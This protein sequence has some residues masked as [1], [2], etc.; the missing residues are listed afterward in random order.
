M[1]D[2]RTLLTVAQ[3]VTFFENVTLITRKKLCSKSKDEIN[4]K[5][6]QILPNYQLCAYFEDYFFKGN[7]FSL[8]G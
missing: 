6:L 7:N 5:I 1:V 4:F 2:D 8:K 3:S